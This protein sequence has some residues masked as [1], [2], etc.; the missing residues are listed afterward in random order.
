MKE[1]TC[2]VVEK[3]QI[4]LRLELFGTPAEVIGDRHAEP[5]DQDLSGNG[6]PDVPD[7]LSDTGH[8]IFMVTAG[9]CHFKDITGRGET[10]RL[11]LTVDLKRKELSGSIFFQCKSFCRALPDPAEAVCL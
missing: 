2:T 1:N 4:K 5:V 3:R 10:N 9:N 6:F 8:G 7:L 11:F